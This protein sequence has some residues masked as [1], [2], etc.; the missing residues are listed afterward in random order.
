MGLADKLLGFAEKKVYTALGTNI[1][2]ESLIKI[3][4]EH[5]NVISSVFFDRNTEHDRPWQATL[6][7]TAKMIADGDSPTV[8]G[9]GT[10]PTQAL[11]NALTALYQHPQYRSERKKRKR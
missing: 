8:Y 7:L 4:D 5:S 6:G 9:R 11:T 3:F 10:T 1:S 2:D